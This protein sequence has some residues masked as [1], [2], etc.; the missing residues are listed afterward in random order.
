MGFTDSQ[1]PPVGGVTI[2][3][4]HWARPKCSRNA[5]MVANMKNSCEN[6]NGQDT[7]EMMKTP[8]KLADGS[9]LTWKSAEENGIEVTLYG[10]DFADQVD[11]SGYVVNFP[12]TMKPAEVYRAGGNAVKMFD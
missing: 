10:E 11:G 4:Q 3:T 5:I 12:L 1:N 9:E 2:R 6:Q 7:L 8:I